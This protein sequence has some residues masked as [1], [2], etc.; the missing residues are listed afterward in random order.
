MHPRGRA[1]LVGWAGNMVEGAQSP[2]GKPWLA[3]ALAGRQQS[4]MYVFQSSCRCGQ[5]EL[6]HRLDQD[7][8]RFYR[9]VNNELSTQGE[10]PHPS[11]G[12]AHRTKQNSSIP[13]GC[14]EIQN[15]TT[16]ADGWGGH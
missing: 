2:K 15:D 4:G 16:T 8:M 3:V 10:E 7:D 11:W 12:A 13:A 5:T 14:T 9:P 6:A 1:E